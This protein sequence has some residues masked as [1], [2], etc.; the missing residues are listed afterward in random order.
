[1]LT[2][3]WPCWLA[4]PLASCTCP[5]PLA[6]TISSRWL[7]IPVHSLASSSYSISSSHLDVSSISPHPYSL[8]SAAHILVVSSSVCLPLSPGS[9]ERTGTRLVLCTALASGPSMGPQGALRSRIWFSSLQASGLAFHY[10]MNADMRL[11]S[12]KQRT[13]LPPR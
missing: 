3:L 7:C 4:L 6:A 12:W 8:Q 13:F 1:M 9:S 2:S 10:S 11:Q 5:A